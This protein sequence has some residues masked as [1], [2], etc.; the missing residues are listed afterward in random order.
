MDRDP[1]RTAIRLARRLERLGP[2][3]VCVL[4]GYL[5]PFALIPILRTLLEKH[6]VVME[7]HDGE[8]TAPVCRNCH[9]VATEKLLQERISP[10]FEPDNRIRIALVL[11]ALA[12]FFEMLAP[13]LRRWAEQLREEPNAEH[14]LSSRPHG[15]KG[16]TKTRESDEK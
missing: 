15:K 14:N 16:K 10:Q 1:N 8:L 11:T 3:P 2:D 4:C 13:A 12:V 9:A 5:D 7:A 6:H